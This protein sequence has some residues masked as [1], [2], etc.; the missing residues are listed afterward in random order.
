MAACSLARVDGAKLADGTASERD[1]Q[2]LT[3]ATSVQLLIHTK[4]YEVRRQNGIWETLEDVTM[5]P[6]LA[7]RQRRVR[8]RFVSDAK[9]QTHEPQLSFCLLSAAILR[10]N[11]D[12]NTTTFTLEA[13]RAGT[14]LNRSEGTAYLRVWTPEPENAATICEGDCQIGRARHGRVRLRDIPGHGG[15]LKI[16]SGDEIHSLDVCCLDKGCVSAFRPG[17]LSSPAVLALS[18]PKEPGEVGEDGYLLWQWTTETNT[19][20]RLHCLP[21][22]AVLRGSNE[23][24]W[25]VQ[26]SGQPMAIGLAWK[27][28]WLGASWDVDQILHYIEMRTDLSESEFAILKWLRVPVLK[29][30]FS[31]AL[32]KKIQ[33]APCQFI[34]S[35]LKDSAI[36]QGLRPH[37]N[38]G[39]IDFVVRHFLWSSF[40]PSQAR[41][42][43]GILTGWD[44]NLSHSDRYIGHLG[45]L[46]DVSP[47]LM[48]KGLECFLKH[49]ARNTLELIRAFTCARLGLT[50]N[51]NKAWIRSRLEFLEKRA[52]QVTGINGDRLSDIAN[53]WIK[54]MH[55]NV[56]QPGDSER[57]ELARIGETQS[58]RHYIST[59]MCRYWLMLSGE[60]EI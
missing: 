25:K 29:P 59:S 42:A 15:E 5:T 14:E 16:L 49:D 4:T 60:K 43:M 18:D 28:C 26:L 13:L 22:D 9:R 20:A 31:L 51:A 53:G 56:W 44:G 36:P 8:V 33:R 34:R 21:I 41:E 40:P 45:Q 58:G 35:W 39:G 55:Q 23:H 6:E 24:T 12:Q 7:G 2:R 32:A 52:A 47:V 37:D 17:L 50:S 3:A 27:G 11:Q 19:K 46:A 38:I 30:R 1:I 54:S 48:W 57:L 10:S